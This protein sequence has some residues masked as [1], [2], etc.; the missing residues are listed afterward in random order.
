MKERCDYTYN[1]ELLFE[2]LMGLSETSARKSYYPELQQHISELEKYKALINYSTDAVFTF[3]PDTGCFI[4]VNEAAS[5]QFGA[6]PEELAARSLY[7][8]LDAATAEK[9]KHLRPVKGTPTI[10]KETFITSLHTKTQEIMPVEISLSFMYIDDDVYGIAVARNI[11]ER[12]KAERELK[13]SKKK[14]DIITHFTYDWETWTGPGKNYIYVSPSCRRITGYAAE[15]FMKNPNLLLS[16][17]HPDDRDKLKAHIDKN[18][19]AEDIDS[20]DFRIITRGG[21]TRWISH[22]CQRAHDSDGAFVGRRGSNRDITERKQIQQRLIQAQ[23]MESVGTLAGGIAHEFNNIL[24]GIMGYAEITQYKLPPGSALQKNM[25]E[26]LKL[27]SRA[28]DLVRQILTFSRKSTVSK[29]RLEP[30]QVIT[31][32]IKMLRNIIPSNVDIRTSISDHCGT[33][34][35]DETQLQQ[36]LINLSANAV[37]A[38]ESRGGTLD[39][40]LKQVF[41]SAEDIK[42]FQHISPGTYLQLSVS[43]TGCGIE[44]HIIDRILEPF[45]TTKGVGKGTGMGLAVVHGIISEHEGG[46]SVSSRPGRGSTFTVVLPV[47]EGTA[48]RDALHKEPVQQQ[49]SGRILIVDDEEFI[50]STMKEIL[51]NMGY[52]VTATTSSPEAL[53]LFR[54]E[55]N[56]YDLIITD[57]M[58]PA[59]TGDRL[60]AEAL[61]IRPDISVVLA[62]GYGDAAGGTKVKNI[63]AAAVL[64]KPFKMKELVETVRSV[65]DE[66]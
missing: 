8:F 12:L 16:I 20:L 61:R 43:D 21:E 66:E 56:N 55:P 58:M 24:G 49:R 37:Q 11:T 38:M 29:K 14:Y 2:K 52:P 30:H 28:G 22:Y 46:I 44:P 64:P 65:L 32:Q 25:E 50:V 19:A 40:S 13:E 6:P 34:M 17:T 53:E 60:A 23:K 42:P 36:I 59:L 26:I 41:L 47:A 45:F 57:L 31:E 63:G 15:N 3:S 10:R 7:D 54:R 39:I 62:T 4:D 33:I 27:G 51:E 35:T 5:H 9:I 1:R 48:S 18:P